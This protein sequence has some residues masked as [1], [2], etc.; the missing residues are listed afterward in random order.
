MRRLGT[1]LLLI[2]TGFAAGW[3]SAPRPES[4]APVPPAEPSAAV[5]DPPSTPAPA[6]AP[7]REI[8]RV[9]EPVRIGPATGDPDRSALG[10]TVTDA[11]GR[12]LAGREVR[13][14]RPGEDELVLSTDGD[15]AAALSPLPPGRVEVALVVVG[16]R[17]SLMADVVAG[18]RTDVAIVDPGGGVV[19]AGRA[20]HREDGALVD[21][22]VRL[23]CTGGLVLDVRETRTGPDGRFRFTGVEPGPARMIVAAAP[24][25]EFTRLVSSSGVEGWEILLGVVS[26]RGLVKDGETGAPL[27]EVRVDLFGEEGPRETTDGI[28]AFR[29]RDLRPGTRTLSFRGE[30]YV[31]SLRKVEVHSDS[32]AEVEVALTPAAVL[33]IEAVDTYGDPF[34]GELKVTVTDATGATTTT[35]CTPDADGRIDWDSFEPVGDCRVSLEGTEDHRRGKAGCRL[36]RGP[37]TVRVRLE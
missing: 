11:E 14:V 18:R 31:R 9:V 2:L 33:E 24:W 20:V 23:E 7:P 30:G 32:V 12:R 15:G 27:S 37:N 26:V 8:L 16:G 6:P 22:L 4:A 1:G 28:G 29:L 19:V 13:V 25:M 3:L 36:V 35:W 21:T 5:P 34:R 10:I 17:R